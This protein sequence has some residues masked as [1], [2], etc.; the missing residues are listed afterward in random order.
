MAITQWSDK[1]GKFRDLDAADKRLL[2]RAT[3]S[4]ASARMMLLVIP[5]KKL[6][7]HLMADIGV[8]SDASNTELINR[9]GRA[10]AVAANNVPWRSDCFPQTIA[11]RKLLQREGIASTIHFGVERAGGSDLI[12]HAWL[13]CG[14]I[15]VTGGS[16][17][18][19]YT[20][21]HRPPEPGTT[22]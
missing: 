6:S 21:L 4:L 3:A 9:I 22:L 13:T 12:G 15:V 5:F 14:D 1:L 16:E 7:S 18:H 11:A 2:F 8:E 17:L 10:V 19:R 20:E